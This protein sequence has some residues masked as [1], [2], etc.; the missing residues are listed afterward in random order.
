M[1]N[2][3]ILLDGMILNDIR[4]GGNTAVQVVEGIHLHYHSV[5]FMIY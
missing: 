4:G 1:A 3:G 2:M 5:L